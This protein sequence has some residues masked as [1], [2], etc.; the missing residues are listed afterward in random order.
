QHMRKASLLAML[1]TSFAALADANE[2][3]IQVQ[4]GSWTVPANDVVQMAG[5]IQAA[6]AGARGRRG[7]PKDISTYVIQYQGAGPSS[8]RV[9]ELR[10]SCEVDAHS[11]EERRKGFFNTMDGGDCY[12][13]AVW[14]AKA[15]KFKIFLF[16]GVA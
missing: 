5:K 12:F 3:W 1:L 2:N 9:I 14:D 7:A 10:G 15:M 4:G 8:A 11:R 16:N 6:A 13:S